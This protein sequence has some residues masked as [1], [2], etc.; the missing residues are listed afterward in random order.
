MQRLT[1]L[2]KQ[3]HRIKEKYKDA[4][5]LFRLGDFYETFYEDATTTSRVLNLVLTSRPWGKHGRIPLAGFPE[6]AS[7]NYI[8]KLVKAGYKVAIC[9]Q[10]EDPKLAKAIVKREVVEVI[11]PGT[12]SRPTLL[13]DRDNNYLSAISTDGNRCGF[14]YCDVSTGEF[15]LTE[16]D[17]EALNEEIKRIEPKEILVPES[18]SY[19][20]NGTVTKLEDYLFDFSFAYEK[21]K[22]H[23]KVASLEGF[24]CEDLRLGVA[25]SGAVFS[26]LE[27]T[28]K[29]TLA[30]ISKLTPYS[31]NEFMLIDS[32]TKK[33]LELIERIREEEKEGTLFSILD[34]TNTSM[35]ARRLKKWI[36]L[37]LLHIGEIK[38]RQNAVSVLTENSTLR[39]SVRDKLKNIS[40]IER[41]VSRL[42]LKKGTPRDLVSLKDSLKIF[43][44]LKKI[45]EDCSSEL[46]KEIY[47]NIGDFSEL[48]DLIESSIVESPPV[49]FKEG[50]IIKAG[51]DPRI[52]ELREI[53]GKGKNFIASI[54]KREREKTGIS[55][56]KVGYN[57]VFGYYIEVTKPNL[58]L[59]PKDYIRKQTLVNAER[60]ITEELKEYEQKVL[61]AEERLR[62][63]EY[64]VFQK[65]RE[66]VA[67]N[68]SEIQNSAAS[69]SALDCI[70]SL[71]TVGYENNYTK[72][73]VDDEDRIRI[74]A[75]KHPVVE[76]LLI[77]ESFVP[78]DVE[79][80]RKENRILIITGPNM[81]GKSTYLRQVALIVVLAQIG[82]WVPAERAQIGVVDKIFTRIGASDDLSRGVSTF[83]AEMNETANILNNATDKSLILL[84]EIG[85]GTATF[86]GLSI[87]WAVV[88]YL[89]N[90]P[91]VQAKTLFATHYHQLTDLESVLPGVKNYNVAC[92]EV[93]E[94]VIFLRKVLPGSADR[95]YGVQV[96]RLAGLPSSVI[97][98]AKEVLKNLE[99]DEYITGHI[100][101]IAR[102]RHAP[103]IEGVNQLNIFVE[104]HPILKKLREIDI[105]NLT[106]VEA[107][108]K[109]DE[110]KKKIE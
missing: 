87:A 33:N 39:K 99:S 97:E 101:K 103:K 48:V 60:F 7:E 108:K 41:T 56:L 78:N 17:R 47:S 83:L 109:L 88:E 38:K 23:F 106:P 25:A 91:K 104:E 53:S 59:V 70:S 96:A 10:V 40:D 58:K 102:G 4:L 22:S 5:L 15:Y 73:E 95:S 1:P 2:L 6:K 44:E 63:I 13:N 19:K 64:E 89:H 110:L 81:A 26:Y 67:K 77:D 9:E 92:K 54:Q 16:L 24:G 21:L 71:A 86:D 105:N 35:G 93:G 79:L 65:L 80:G 49:Q 20:L 34:R 82:C 28:Q 68:T 12:I 14:V 27:E 98:R 72:P 69:I 57:T 84:D 50:G 30:N 3:Y 45:I 107:L 18:F 36:L 8:A 90:N 52:D 31:V 11:T 29:R 46:L 42:A 76:K 62:E 37:P 51:F 94:R 43:P 74:V 55:S 61:G 75:G 32:T 66:R 100:P 85:R